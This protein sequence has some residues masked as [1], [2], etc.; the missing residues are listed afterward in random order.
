MRAIIT[1]GQKFAREPHPILPNAHPDGWY[2]IEV[3]DDT[4][5]AGLNT[6]VY[7][8]LG[9][10]WSMAY[11]PDFLSPDWESF[12]PRGKLGDLGTVPA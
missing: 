1:F 5:Q 7:A 3:P 4:D 10:D 12:L 2:E 8:I 6:I 11:R 9:S